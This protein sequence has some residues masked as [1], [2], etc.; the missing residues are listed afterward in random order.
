[1]RTMPVLAVSALVG[2]AVGLWLP[3]FES[4]FCWPLALVVLGPVAWWLFGPGVLMALFALTLSGLQCHG[5]REMLLPELLGGQDI[6]VRGIVADLPRD[7]GDSVSFSFRV[8]QDDLLRSFPRRITLT[9]YTAEPRPKAGESWQFLARLKRPLATV[10]RDSFDRE[11][12]NL[13]N[14]IHAR[15]YV[16]SSPLNR[17]LQQRYLSSVA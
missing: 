5:Y 11:V 17:R 7:D 1:M 3:V 14:H 8:L 4:G 12:W 6:V 13:W 16:R 9:I 15:G 2:A 10:N